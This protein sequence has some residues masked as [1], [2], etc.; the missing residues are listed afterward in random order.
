MKIQQTEQL[1]SNGDALFLTAYAVNHK[2]PWRARI[3]RDF[4]D[5]QSFA[6]AERWDGKEWREAYRILDVKVLRLLR[7]STHKP[8]TEWL[9]DGKRDA[10]D[11]LKSA[12][13]AVGEPV[14]PSL[15]VEELTLISN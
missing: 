2:T 7:Y 9:L 13:L 12:A 14:R 10:L 5:H 3:K 8:T 15:Q 4:Y 6:I 11:L 1:T